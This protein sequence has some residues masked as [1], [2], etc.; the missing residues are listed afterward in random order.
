MERTDFH[1]SE[2]TSALAEELARVAARSALQIGAENFPVALRLLPRRPRAQLTRVYQ[3]ARFVDDI[4]DEAVG[5]RLGMLDRIERD[6]RA[7]RLGTATLP[8]VVGL[9]PV[10]SECAVPIEPFLDLVEANRV[11]QRVTRYETFDDLLGYCTLSAAPVG[12]VVLHIAGAATEQNLAYSDAVCAGLQVLEHCQD[13]REDARAGRIYL[14]ASDLRIA[15]V[16]DDE[17]TVAL[18]SPKLRRVTAAQVARAEALLESGRPLVRRLHGWARL[19][20]AG[21]LAGGQATARALRAADF[22]VLASTVRP[23]KTATI[24]GAARL[25]ARG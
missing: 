10:I 1:R 16:D 7:L 2:G 14:P 17:L 22:N 11:D 13:V 25:M 23:R 9:G 24:A 12:R 15:G 20:V 21:Y 3:Y 8:P 18:T 6:V 4:G 5:D 19:A